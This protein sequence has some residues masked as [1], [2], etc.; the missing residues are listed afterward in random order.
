MIPVVA[1]I[2]WQRDIAPHIK[3]SEKTGC[4]EWTKGLNSKG[5]AVMYPTGDRPYTHR[6]CYVHRVA[7]ECRVG[8]IP[9]RLVIDHLCRNK[10]CVNPSHLEPVT[11]RENVLRGESPNAL[12]YHSKKCRRGHEIP[13][14]PPGLRRRCLECQR[15]RR[16]FQAIREKGSP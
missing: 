15:S 16:R 12:V 3:I 8:P 6:K 13:D 1:D 2:S 5:Y 14:P 10:R 9:H 7:Y 11:N 4:W